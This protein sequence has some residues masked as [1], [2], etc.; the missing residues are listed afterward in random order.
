MKKKPIDGGNAKLETFE[1]VGRSAHSF[2]LNAVVAEVILNSTSPTHQRTGRRVRRPGPCRT[3]P[4]RCPQTRQ[5]TSSTAQG[6]A[7]ATPGHF[8]CEQRG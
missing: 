3:P 1:K 7:R 2:Q 6:P 4:A 8:K 5:T